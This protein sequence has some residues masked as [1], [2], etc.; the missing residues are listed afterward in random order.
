M[1]EEA[2]ITPDTEV[3]DVAG[4]VEAEI[5]KNPVVA[6]KEEHK[7]SPTTVPLPVYLELKEELKSLK[8]EIKEAKSSEKSKVAL[9]GANDLAKKYPDVSEDFI[10][11]ILNSA[12]SEATKKIKE[13]YSPIIER[14][15]AEKR[16]VAF[17]K[18]F[19]NLFDKAMEEYPELPKNIDREAIKDLA[20]TAKYRNIPVADIILKMYPISNAG[21]SS[22]E[23]DMRTGAERVS[24]VVNFDNITTEQRSAVMDDPKARA[25]FFDYLDQGNFR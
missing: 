20:V 3:K 13:E 21:K 17:D 2:I 15:D 6:P 25:K 16:Q 4:S 10:N 12:T 23:N 18:A 1:A 22:S 8:Q 24:D 11:D 5:A 19:D 9:A 7:Q 14:Q